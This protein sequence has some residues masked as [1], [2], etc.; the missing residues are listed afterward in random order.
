MGHDN[1]KHR[2]QQAKANQ[3]QPIRIDISDIPFHQCHVCGGSSFFPTIKLK[4][5]PPERHPL[6]KKDTATF[7]AISCIK[8]GTDYI[9]GGIQSEQ[10]P[11][12]SMPGNVEGQGESGS[13]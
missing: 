6:L 13:N 7:Q 4:V 10:N 8:C 3:P 1:F 2:L 9:E 5:I 12:P 11:T